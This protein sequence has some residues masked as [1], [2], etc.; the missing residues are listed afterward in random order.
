[1]IRVSNEDFVRTCVAS[2]SYAEVATATGLTTASVQTRFAKLRKLGV[3]LPTYARQKKA[4]DVDALN[5]LIPA[6]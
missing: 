2:K 4:L 6:V 3:N 1:M 5:A